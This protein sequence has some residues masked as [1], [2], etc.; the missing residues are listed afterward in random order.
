MDRRGV[1][2]T[3]SIVNTAS[4]GPASTAPAAGETFGWKSIWIQPE[5]AG[6]PR[7]P[8]VRVVEFAGELRELRR[9]DLDLGRVLGVGL[10]PADRRPAP[11]PPDTPRAHHQGSRHR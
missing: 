9:S 10:D 8:S 2:P 5:V 6:V 4:V 3:C 7:R 11:R 1:A